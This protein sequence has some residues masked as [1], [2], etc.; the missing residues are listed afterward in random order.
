M[1]DDQTIVQ[2]I[3]TVGFGTILLIIIGVII[4]AIYTIKSLEDGEEEWGKIMM[5]VFVFVFSPLL[6]VIVAI[7]VL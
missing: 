3:V 1:L 6:I 2:I 5:L 4:F 7:L